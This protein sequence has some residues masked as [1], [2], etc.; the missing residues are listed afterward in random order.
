MAARAEMA[1]RVK[2][3]W[4]KQPHGYTGHDLNFV[5]SLNLGNCNLS[6]ED[7]I[8]L[9]SVLTAEERRPLKIMDLGGNR[10]Q[11]GALIALVDAF[12]RG[13]VPMLS[14]LH[15]GHNACSDVGLTALSDALKEGHLPR[16]DALHL[17]RNH[18]GPDGVKAL[19]DAAESGAL[20]LLTCLSLSGNP[21]GDE[22]VKYFAKAAADD[23]VLPKLAELHLCET[24]V[25]G[26]GGIAAL[27]ETLMP[28]TG[29]LP[30]LRS[31]HVDE[32]YK[33]HPRL[34]EVRQARNG[35]GGVHACKIF[36]GYEA[37]VGKAQ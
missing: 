34:V 3:L 18:F 19:V 22:S 13:G 37:V 5:V 21:I 9:G 17:D 24:G 11:D 23:E 27:C 29:G 4:S 2:E 26:D 20:K 30:Q 33:A 31:L 12:V 35:H 16:L 7:G 8:A 15:I 14:Y 6:D 10:F 28:R 25:S 32:E 1:R 36:G